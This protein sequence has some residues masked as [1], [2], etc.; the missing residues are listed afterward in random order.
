MSPVSNKTKQKK[1][2]FCC[3]IL[4][5]VLNQQVKSQVEIRDGLYF[6]LLGRQVWIVKTDGNKTSRGL[7]YRVSKDSVYYVETPLKTLT[8]EIDHLEIKSLHH[9][10]I[11]TMVTLKNKPVAKGAVAG[12]LIGFAAGIAIRAATY[13]PDPITQFTVGVT[14]GEGV[15]FIGA[16][17]L[18]AT[19][20]VATGAGIGLIAKKKWVIGGLESNFRK[21]I[22]ELD[23]RAYWNR[24]YTP[25]HNYNS[26]ASLD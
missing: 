18:G 19:A 10:Q 9:T 21:V 26:K 15:F 20:G 11:D 2:I 4:F 25:R 7:L 16:G 8:S 13:D 1:L 24:S 3:L 12:V 5:L 14:G 22:L 23:K 6:N 17:L